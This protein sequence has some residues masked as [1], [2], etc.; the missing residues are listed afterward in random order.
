MVILQRMPHEMGGD[1]SPKGG[2][3]FGPPRRP[4]PDPFTIAGMALAAAFILDFGIS[5]LVHFFA[6]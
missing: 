6:Q 5:A 3:V 4:R 1:H 2:P